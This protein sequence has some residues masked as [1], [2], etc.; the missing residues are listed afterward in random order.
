MKI[1]FLFSPEGDDGSSNGGGSTTLL[2]ESA[3]Q[4]AQQQD[5]QAV[6]VPDFIHDKF[7]GAEN[8]IEAQ[9]RA[10][11]DAQKLIGQR[12]QI[13]PPGPDAKPEEIKAWRTSLGVPET[14][15]AYGLK[16]PDKLPEGVDWNEEDAK[17][18]Q[19]L[20]H[21]IGLTPAQVAKLTEYDLTRSGKQVEGSKAKMESYL[22]EQRTALK[23]EWGDKFENNKE[24][25]VMAAKLLGLDPN[26]AEL[27]N[28]AKMIKALYEAS[29]LIQEDKFV[30]SDKVGLGLTN[31]EQ[32]DDI[33]HNK[34]NP[35][36]K[37]FMGQE[38]KER[39]AEAQRHRNRLLGIKG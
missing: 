39:Q 10:Y 28:S 20:A 13:K 22:G 23:T 16:K 24:R 31:K 12:Q 9:A 34:N 35:W 17:G 3:P 21:E 5:G 36:H 37:A 11:L 1:R 29:K 6:T 25:A 32:A 4:Q 26:D 2:S 33:L 7:K 19:T 18:F 14:P 15:D 27:G 8:P 38:T 30:G